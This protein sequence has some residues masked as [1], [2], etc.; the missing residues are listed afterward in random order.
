VW[1]APAKEF[2]AA[3]LVGLA[4]RRGAADA[5]DAGATE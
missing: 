3:H 2:L 1:D 4:A 5:A